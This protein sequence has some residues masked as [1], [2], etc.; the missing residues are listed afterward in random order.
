MAVSTY[1][2]QAKPRYAPGNSGDT[3][4]ISPAT[5]LAFY[6]VLWLMGGGAAPSS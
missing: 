3:I 5:N 1:G 6:S 2:R 4:P